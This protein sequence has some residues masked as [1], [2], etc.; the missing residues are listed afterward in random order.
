MLEKRQIF[1]DVMP[2]EEAEEQL[3]Q[4]G[5][6]SETQGMGFLV[7]PEDSRDNRTIEDLRDATQEGV[8]LF[9]TSRKTRRR[10]IAAGISRDHIEMT[11]PR[12]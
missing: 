6:K 2:Y 11:I 7:M 4:V 5:G 10:L 9:C 1:T 8:V 3:H 12:G